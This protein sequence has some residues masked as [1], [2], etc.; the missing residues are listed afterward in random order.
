MA[1]KQRRMISLSDFNRDIDIFH[2]HARAVLDSKVEFLIPLDGLKGNF[3]DYPHITHAKV[4][5]LKPTDRAG[6][7]LYGRLHGL[8]DGA[9]LEDVRKGQ[10]VAVNVSINGND[11]VLFPHVRLFTDEL[12]QAEIQ[13]SRS[14]L[15]TER[16]P[17]FN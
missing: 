15:N 13:W 16:F 6:S 10:P 8:G 7:L 9:L 4:R 3:D 5:V 12:R 2:E 17:Y 14:T 1:S 11:I